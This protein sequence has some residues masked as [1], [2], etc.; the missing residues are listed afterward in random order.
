M[1]DAF[2]LHSVR[3]V[4]SLTFRNTHMKNTAT[5]APDSPRHPAE[6]AAPPAA[7]TNPR[8]RFLRY[9]GQIA[10]SVGGAG[11]ASIA[12]AQATPP[13]VSFTP[14]F[15]PTEKP[16]ETPKPDAWSDRVG[17]A[18]VGLGRLALNEILPAMAMSRH[19]KAVALVSGD[20]EKAGKVARQYNIRE[21]AIYDYQSFDRLAE[22]PEVQ[23]IYI[24]LPNSMHLEFTLRGARAGKHILCEKPMANSVADCQK[25]IDACK[26]ANRQLMIAY[27]SQYEGNDRAMVKMVREGRF[28]PL[29]EIL[30]S[31]SQHQGDPEQ[32]RHK[33]ALAGGG[34]LPDVGIY[35]INAA[36]FISGEEPSEVIGHV[37]N[38]PGDPR[39]R[40]IEESAQFIMKFPSG[41]VATATTSYAVHTSKYLRVA[42]PKGWAE[43]NPA[44]SYSGI[45]LA[46]SRL[47]DKHE[48]KE[49]IAIESSDQFARMLDHMAVCARENRRP[50]TPGEEGLQDQ[51]IVEAIY[52]SAREG[53]PVKLS[54]P[55]GPVRGPEPEES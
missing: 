53:R 14:I 34:P 33:K 35:C 37:I 9:A 21:E 2:R 54:Q 49:D 26:A 44:F 27:R 16:E 11:I 6:T 42:G 18:I 1:N 31:N 23:V 12:A 22:N 36:R 3:V 25:M 24:I 15:A 30:S 32:W 38:N 7:G 13:V 5:P 45:K 10:A 43:L 46:T 4:K 29:R 47:V 40:E 52:R 8:R 55:V 50:H 48:V 17:F 41:L 51:R 39:F 19:C 28:G 20:R